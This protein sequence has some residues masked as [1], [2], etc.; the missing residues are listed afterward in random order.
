[1]VP[2]KRSTLRLLVLAL[3]MALLVVAGCNDSNDVSNVPADQAVEAGLNSA[4]QTTVVPLV[5]FMGALGDLLN[6]P[7]AAVSPRGLACPNTSEWCT[8][9]AVVCS[10]TGTGYH[11]DFDECQA[12]TGDGPITLDGD[13]DVAPSTT[14]ALTFTNFFINNSPAIS[15]TGSIDQNNCDYNVDV[16][17]SDVAVVGTVTDCGD[18][19]PWPTGDQLLVSFDDFLLTITLNGSQFA[20][21]IATSGGTPVATCSIDLDSQP[22]TSVCDPID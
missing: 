5:T 3:A 21:V 7:A 19:D 22:L 4:L 16:H 17:T 8:T 20:S 6:P 13:I 14:I 18:S 12:V 15:G 11:F 2:M 9:G 10:V 1:M